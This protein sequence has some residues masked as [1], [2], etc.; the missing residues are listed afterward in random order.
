M[1]LGENNMKKVK[2]I[3]LAVCLL[4]ACIPS[5]VYAKEA[6]SMALAPAPRYVDDVNVILGN[7]S[8]VLL[9]GENGPNFYLVPNVP[10]YLKLKT[11]LWNASSVTTVHNIEIS[12]INSSD[13]I[14]QTI[15]LKDYSSNTPIQFKAPERDLY[16][17]EVWN[18]GFD[19]I[20]IYQSELY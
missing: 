7:G 4:F 17:L 2:G 13:E 1:R 10:Y 11:A 6:A 5:S 14:V 8:G 16:H 20:V 12:L 3:V 19:D 18:F 9:N 15:F